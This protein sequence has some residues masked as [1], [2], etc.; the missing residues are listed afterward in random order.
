[1]G[2]PIPGDL[3][4]RERERVCHIIAPAPHYS[5]MTASLST[6]SDVTPHR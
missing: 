2:T 6:G 5:R 1:M 4:Q 3:G